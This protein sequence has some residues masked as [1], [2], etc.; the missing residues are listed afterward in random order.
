VELHISGSTLGDV[1]MT[2][3]VCASVGFG[4]GSQREKE[5]E[6]RELGEAHF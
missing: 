4:E 2:L 5:R 3:V 6:E 1:G